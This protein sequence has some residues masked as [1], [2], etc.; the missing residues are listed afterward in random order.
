MARSTHDLGF[1]T[2]GSSEHVRVQI[3]TVCAKRART[4]RRKGEYVRHSFDHP[5]TKTPYFEW[6]MERP[7]K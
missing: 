3:R 2:L 5:R 4:L 1:S 7:T 6:C